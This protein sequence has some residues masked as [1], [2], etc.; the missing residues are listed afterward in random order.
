MRWGDLGG[1]MG[2]VDKAPGEDAS[3]ASKGS[4][5]MAPPRYGRS[6]GSGLGGTSPG[7]G[8]PV[9]VLERA[10]VR[11]RRERLTVLPRLELLATERSEPGLWTGRASMAAQD[12]RK[13]S[14]SSPS[15]EELRS[16]S[17]LRSCRK[18]RSHWPTPLM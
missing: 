15:P 8:D 14:T 17:I 11:G 4:C 6:E 13:K 2:G 3:G 5:T 16:G 1:R 18:R 12:G 10:L 9:T 7:L